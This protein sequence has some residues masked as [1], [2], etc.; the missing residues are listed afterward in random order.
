MKMMKK[1]LLTKG[2][3][4]LA[5]FICSCENPTETKQP[6]GYIPELILINNNLTF[7][8]GCQ[9]SLFCNGS[10]IPP[11]KAILN[12]YYI[13]KYEIRNDEYNEF[14]ADSGYCDL[15]LWS[16][17]GWKYIQSEN[18]IRPVGW[19]ESDEPWANC[20]LSNTP[21]RP[22]NNITWYEAEAYCNWLSRKTGE[23]YSL[24][25]EAQWE[26]AARGP[27]PGRIFPWGNKDDSGKYNSVL[28]S[29]K[30]YPVG[31]FN[32]D[33]SYEGCYDM[34]GSL[35]E[36]CSDWYDPFIYKIYKNREPVFNPVGSDSATLQ[37]SLRGAF[38]MY[39]SGPYTKAQIT[40]FRRG[41]CTPKEHYEYNGF[42]IVKNI[43]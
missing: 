18:R 25:T 9:D 40:N 15:T 30:L 19:I 2:F 13:A 24:P 5:L 10:D 36:F 8:M 21:D 7:T 39:Y 41:G 17:D 20:S 29:K 26:R 34:A 28:F 16:E 42:R 43:D 35:I 31:S 33:K 22:I 38:N 11:F 6:K 14:V 37:R 32:H 3:L 1:I 23:N 4:L 27:D 12:P